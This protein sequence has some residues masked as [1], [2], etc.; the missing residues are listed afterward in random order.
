[1]NCISGLTNLSEGICRGFGKLWIQCHRLSICNILWRIYNLLNINDA[2]V[3]FVRLGQFLIS[4]GP[5]TWVYQLVQI[6]WTGRW[7][8]IHGWST[9]LNWSQSMRTHLTS[10]HQFQ[11]LPSTSAISG[12]FVYYSCSATG[13]CT[14]PSGW[15]KSNSSTLRGC[16]WWQ[17]PRAARALF[18]QSIPINSLILV[19][20]YYVKT[21]CDTA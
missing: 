12:P 15:L 19:C 20:L 2:P 9:L 16:Q 7:A 17:A 14:A 21:Y 5:V 18:L 1:M 3:S 6:I 13:F 11:M 10:D 4:R 8:A